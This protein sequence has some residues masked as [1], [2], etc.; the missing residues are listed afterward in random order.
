MDTDTLDK[1]LTSHSEQITHLREMAQ[2]AR[3]ETREVYDK[4]HSKHVHLTVTTVLWA[5]LAI[6]IV[7]GLYIRESNIQAAREARAELKYQEYKQDRESF[8]KQLKTSYEERLLQQ[9]IQLDE[10]N[11]RASYKVIADKKKDEVNKPN[12][13]TVQVAANL[14]NV[15]GFD[16]L[17]TDDNQMAVMLGLD[18]AKVVTVTKIEHTQLLLDNTS[19]NKTI[20]SLTAEKSSLEA[21]LTTCKGTVKKGEDAYAELKKVK[22]Q[23]K[24]KTVFG[25]VR[26]YTV[27]AAIGY[28]I[29]SL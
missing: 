11:K 22:K 7:G 6:G 13:T 5:L 28:I 12:L 26:D 9:Q 18:Q 8:E 23:S 3:S 14:A 21:D 16:N 2:E 27:G 25:K 29:K 15:Y 1:F 4:L 20:T 19:L 17:K 24:W 10:A